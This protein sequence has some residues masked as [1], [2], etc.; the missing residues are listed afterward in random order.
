MRNGGWR[1]AICGM[2]ALSI[3]STVHAQGPA[4]EPAAPAAAELTALLRAFLDGASPTTPRS[5]SGSGPTTSST[6]A[7]RAS[8]SARRTSS[9]MPARH[10]PTRRRLQPP[11]PPRTSASSSSARPRWSPSGSSGP[12]ARARAG[13]PRRYL[14][15]GTFVKRGGRWQ[16]VAWQATRAKA[17]D[18]ATAKS[19]TPNMGEVFFVLL[20]K[21]P[22]WTAER[23]DATAAI[24]AAHMANIGGCG[25][26][27]R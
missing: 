14:N 17:E 1:A 3:T 21:G 27:R 20:E 16:A 18:P 23:T 19:D 25:T 6:P 15:T 26:R 4:R 5:T 7:P 8:G 2:V 11:T 22:E 10:R 24:Q 12:G 13:V 9:A